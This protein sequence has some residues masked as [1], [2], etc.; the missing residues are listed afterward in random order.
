MDIQK[1]QIQQHKIDINLQ[2]Y[3]FLK[4][5]VKLSPT[6]RQLESMLEIINSSKIDTLNGKNKSLENVFADKKT[7]KFNKKHEIFK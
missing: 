1:L 3:F 6:D 7:D 5:I 2:F 4:H